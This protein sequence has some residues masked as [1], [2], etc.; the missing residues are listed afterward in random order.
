MT[1]Y[2]DKGGLFKPNTYKLH[3]QG[4]K[5]IEAIKK[6]KGYAIKTGVQVASF[7]RVITR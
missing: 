3:L 5:V 6:N 1:V 2:R 4:V 7:E